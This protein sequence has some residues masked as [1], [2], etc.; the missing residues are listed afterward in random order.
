MS[1]NNYDLF[2]YFGG[3]ETF[4]KPNVPQKETDATGEQLG[5]ASSA[6]PAP[7]SDTETLTMANEASVGNATDA[8]SKDTCDNGKDDK[9]IVYLASNRIKEQQLRKE[10][11]EDACE[12]NCGDNGASENELTDED[13]EAL[14]DDPESDDDVADKAELGG[15]SANT[16]VVK[17]DSKTTK[18]EGDTAAKKEEKKPVFNHATYI[19]Y[20]GHNLS[21][22]KFFGQEVLGTLDLEAVRKRLEK[23]FPELSKQRTK[24]DFDDKKNIICPMVTGGKKGA[25]FSSG[26]KGFFFRSKDLFENKEPINIMAAQDGYYEVRENAIGVFVS[27]APVVEELEPCREGFKLS[28]PKIPENLFA[29]LVSFFAD[30][31]LH[32]VEVMGVFYWDKE[33]ER[34]VLDVPFQNVTKDSIDPCYSEVPLHYIKVAEIHSHNTMATYFSDVDDQ[35]ELGTMLYGVV[36]RLQKGMYEITYDLR[37]RAGVAGRFIPIV[38][39]VMIEGKYPEQAVKSFYP[40][41]YPDKW[42][43]RVR[44]VQRNY[45]SEVIGNG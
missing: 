7:A 5:S 35:D 11:S 22:T 37:T 13:R 23:D 38:P 1:N 4:T 26:L 44:I 28:L 45:K 25:F 12:D 2:S 34:Y 14:S 6:D 19:C 16:E 33:G 41:S 40:A 24:M 31:A 27:K 29:Q 30:Y 32:E 15:G 21:L 42:H 8:S 18:S 3:E 20:A 39:D 10:R 17:M 43:D 36:G 9:K